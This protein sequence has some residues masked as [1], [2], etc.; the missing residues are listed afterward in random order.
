MPTSA[1]GFA[2][3]QWDMV[4]QLHYEVEQRRQHLKARR[5]LLKDVGGTG[6]GPCASGSAF[7]H[8]VTSTQPYRM[9]ENTHRE[10]VCVRTPWYLVPSW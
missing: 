5:L 1:I 8:T 10:R 4:R 3:D 9:Y 2:P 6:Q 7:L